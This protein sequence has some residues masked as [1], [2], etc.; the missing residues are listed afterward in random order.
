MI[1]LLAVL[2]LIDIFL[3]IVLFAC[4]NDTNKSVQRLRKK[5]IKRKRNNSPVPKSIF[6]GL[7]IVDIED[8]KDLADA[9]TKRISLD[10]L[11]R[12]L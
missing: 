12:K 7:E 4:L 11:E 10:Q 3:F 5:L 1:I 8:E 9:A 2:Q 6:K